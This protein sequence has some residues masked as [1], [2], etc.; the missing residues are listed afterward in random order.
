MTKESSEEVHA[1]TKKYFQSI[2]RGIRGMSDEILINVTPP[3][4]RVAIVENGVL[5][6]VLIERARKRG[7]VGLQGQ[8]VPGFARYA[9]GICG[10]RFGAR[11]FPACCRCQ[12]H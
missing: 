9:G 4:T 12:C 1:T 7:L 5:Q 3:E 2:A 11:G 6:E 8:G 10:Y